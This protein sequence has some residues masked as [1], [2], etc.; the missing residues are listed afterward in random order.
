MDISGK[1]K[2][3]RFNL[4]ILAALSVVAAVFAVAW[5]ALTGNSGQ[6][7]FDII[8]EWTSRKGSNK[9]AEMTLLWTVLFGGGLLYIA[10]AALGRLRTSRRESARAGKAALRANVGVVMLAALGAV[11]AVDCVVYSHAN[12]LLLVSVVVGLVAVLRD[13]ALAATALVLYFS[14]YYAE[15][16]LYRCYALIAPEPAVAITE[17]FV[18]VAA[19]AAVALMA[20]RSREKFMLRGLLLVQLAAPGLYLKLVVDR[21]F[22][23][24]AF[25]TIPVP[26]AALVAVAA[27]ILLTLADSIR[28]LAGQW[29]EPRGLAACIGLGACV[30]IMAF[31]GFLASGAVVPSDMHHPGENVMAYMQ[32]FDLGMSAY[33]D[34]YPPSGM[35][36]VM[37]G[38][39]LELFGE[40]FMANYSIATSLFKTL[41]SLLVLLLLDKHV[42]RPIVFMVALMFS[43]TSYNRAFF[44]LPAVLM[45]ALPQLIER[46]SAWLFSWVLV[47]YL[48]GMYYP[49]YGAAVCAGFLPLAAFQVREWVVSG[50]ASADVRRPLFWICVIAL[51]VLVAMGVPVLWGEF[52]H[53]RAMASQSLLADGISIFGQT[54]PGWFLSFLPG[55]GTRFYRIALYYAVRFVTPAVIAWICLALLLAALRFPERG[56]GVRGIAS[57]AAAAFR[58]DPAGVAL[59]VAALV[60]PVVGYTYAYVRMDVGELFARASRLIDIA[61]VVLVVYCSTRL[62]ES[63]AKYVLVA[64]AFALLPLAG[65]MG[66]TS[67]GPGSAYVK[68]GKGYEYVADKESRL[69]EGFID[70]KVMEEVETKK[71]AFE[72][73]DSDIARFGIAKFG[74]YYLLEQPGAYTLEATTAK[75]YSAAQEAVDNLRNHPAAVGTN[76][77]TWGN[78][79]LYHW[80]L[81]SGE[82]SWDAN[83]GVFL[84][85]DEVKSRDVVKAEHWN[86]GFAT[87]DLDLKTH[88]GSLGESM[89]TLRGI[90][91]EP[92]ID[93]D[94]VEKEKGVELRFGAPID[95]DEADFLYLEFDGV[96]DD[97]D[98]VQFDASG[99]HVVKATKLS[100]PLLKKSWN[101]GKKVA[102]EWEDSAGEVHGV[103][104]DLSKG[105]LLVPLGAGKNWLLN[106]HDNLKI[107]LLDN[108]EVTQLP[109]ISHMEF[110]KL[111]EA[112]RD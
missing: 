97:F 70:S 45:L 6:E 63:K 99:E 29:R 83:Q 75:G 25:M 23:D 43:F 55:D 20:F 96:L 61:A 84:R 47:S 57:R 104:C 4:A 102:L 33:Q 87:D 54:I 93:Y 85:N 24:G 7:Y 81:T 50:A 112:G 40:G 82:Y 74:Y 42:D 71:A 19:V 48:L 58:E 3:G 53:I 28:V 10:I 27:A 59:L 18:A 73:I 67:S 107:S 64:I 68:V 91:S 17:A 51:V 90:F 98:Y 110:L 2:V 88:W 35:F 37:H 79:Y 109:K 36:S 34:Y 69:G 100:R 26:A 12:V 94:V 92:N 22:H 41:L 9:S 38:F 60:V 62:E 76:I 89:G 101:L 86:A 65:T 11:A 5:L 80:L 30:A 103:R 8:A 32:V 44:V 14:V 31:N 108:D 95:G 13:R 39:F 77:S 78:Y 15:V 21:Y 105:K 1:V 106:N 16:G 66:L 72:A 56:G 52:Q 46:R 49:V 111:R